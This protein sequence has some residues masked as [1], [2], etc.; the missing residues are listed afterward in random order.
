MASYFDDLSALLDGWVEP[1]RA[2]QL[3]SASVGDPPRQLYLVGVGAGGLA[4][5]RR[6][7]AVCGRAVRDRPALVSLLGLGLDAPG[8]RAVAE[9]TALG[10]YRFRPA[11]RSLQ[12]IA[13]V[14][15]SPARWRAELARAE[16]WI[17]ATW[18]ARDL[19]N[20]PSLEKSPAW[21]ADTAASLA[22]AV[23]LQVRIRSERELAAEGFAGLLAVGAGSS[24][25]PRLVEIGYQPIGRAQAHVVLIGKGITFDSGGLS[26][27]PA[28]SMTTMKT[29]MAGSAAVLAATLALPAAKAGPQVTT[30]MAIAENL[31]SG[32]ALRPG[33]VIRHY[34][35]RT[36]EVMNT[37]AEGRL[38]LADALSYAQEKLSPDVMVDLATLTGA[39]TLGLGRHHAALYSSHD[40]LAAALLAAGDGAGE[41]AW[42]MPLVDDYRRALESDIADL[43]N[44]A[45]AG[46]GFHA[47]SITAALFLREFVGMTPWAHL[48]IAGVGRAESDTAERGKGATGYGARLLLSWL[49]GGQASPP[50]S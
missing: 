37:D 15:D 1:W 49:T 26:L 3:N 5:L 23:G 36:V 16:L 40:W 33:D 39:A 41:P 11:D 10:S 48:D 46:F 17:A 35:G 45:D 22:E 6:A 43:R 25:A 28:D 32:G 30:L 13:L 27:K 12:R 19:A 29:D 18:T 8:L 21:L 20:T 7:A 44:T 24:R 31:P 34:G 4:D 14:V 47:G 50:A 2:G 38:V 42:R 9:A